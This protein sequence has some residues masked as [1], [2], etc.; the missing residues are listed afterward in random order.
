[1]SGSLRERLARLERR[2]ESLR[3]RP[4]QNVTMTVLQ[5]AAR[6][7]FDALAEH[8]PDGSHGAP[9]V[10]THDEKALQEAA[11]RIAAGEPSSADSEL[12]A[13]LPRADLLTL[14]AG[15][16]EFIALVASLPD[17]IDP[18]IES[19][20]VAYHQNSMRTRPRGRRADS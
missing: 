6:R 15:P 13:A 20:A 12:L 1:M 19:I 16:A 5:E 11:A 9:S 4:T 14:G 17:E 3:Q 7:L 8:F 2:V 18:E 10:R